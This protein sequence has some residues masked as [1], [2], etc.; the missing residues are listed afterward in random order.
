MPDLK[1]SQLT[2][3]GTLSPAA[4]IPVIQTDPV[5][6]VVKNFSAM[7]SQFSTGVRLL[8]KLTGANM[9]LANSAAIS[10][11]GA[12]GFAFQIGDT[13]TDSSVAAPGLTKLSA[14][15]VIISDDGK[16]LT[17]SNVN[18]GNDDFPLFTEIY[19]TIGQLTY[20]ALS[21]F[22]AATGGAPAPGGRLLSLGAGADT[23]TGSTSGA[24][25]TVATDDGSS[26]M[27]ISSITG[28]F[29]AGETITGSA[30]ATAVVT[31]YSPPGSAKV[32]SFAFYSGDQPITLSGGTSYILTDIVITHASIPLTTAAGGSL[33]TGSDESGFEIA[34]VTIPLSALVSPASF[35]NNHNGIELTVTTLSESS[36]LD[37]MST[38]TAAPVSVQSP[39]YFSLTTPQGATA[40]ADIYVYG[41][42]L[43]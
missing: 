5:D 21:G 37:G 33:Y 22:F 9:N 42:V 11:A 29:I 38:T 36:G 15:P 31:A 12:G 35:L 17:L 10:Y 30:G 25:A 20:S 7:A 8:G 34:T 3:A 4:I 40:T 1:I 6:G 24:T 32:E 28:T 18:P 41:Y 14:P 39:V 43:N 27:T 2:A 26:S 19:G 23:V 13:V 16:N